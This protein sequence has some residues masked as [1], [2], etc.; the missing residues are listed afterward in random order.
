MST[1]L[2]K[3]E[4]TLNRDVWVPFTIP[5]CCR[6]NSVA[7][8]LAT[9]CDEEPFCLSSAFG[10]WKRKIRW[11]SVRKKTWG[12]AIHAFFL[13][14][15]SI[16]DLRLGILISYAFWG[17]N[18]AYYVLIFLIAFFTKRPFYHTVCTVNDVNIRWNIQQ[19]TCTVRIKQSFNAR[20]NL[21]KINSISG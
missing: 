5:A 9:D 1:A 14:R 17:S 7:P 8:E 19:I 13:I 11:I 15:R 4:I 6:L 18:R 2:V 10:R 20:W 3:L 12:R 16:F 21:E